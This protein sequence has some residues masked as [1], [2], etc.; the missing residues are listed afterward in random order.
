[1]GRQQHV[2]ACQLTYLQN[3]DKHARS[4]P[5][6]PPCCQTIISHRTDSPKGCPSRKRPP[7]VS[8]SHWRP[9]GDKWSMHLSFFTVTRHDFEGGKVGKVVQTQ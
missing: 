9:R 2:G 8:T 4:S 6:P 1:V 7:E 3:I 5:P